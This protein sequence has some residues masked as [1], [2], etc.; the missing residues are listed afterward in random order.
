[1]EEIAALVSWQNG[2][3]IS[4]SLGS[5]GF[6]PVA[7]YRLHAAAAET[8]RFEQV[9]ESPGGRVLNVLDPVGVVAAIVPWNAPQALLAVK[10]APSLLAGCT[11][12]A[13][14]SPE[15]SLD[16]MLLAELLDEA[17]FPRGVVNIITG[18]RETGAAL[19][20]HSGVDMVSFTG[21]AVGGRD[22]ASACGQHL[23]EVTTEL[24]GKSAAVVLDDADLSQLAD[25]LIDTCLPNTGQ[26]C[27][28]STRI[29]APK[30]RL[31]EVLDAV[32]DTLRGARTGDPMDRDSQFGPLVTARQRERVEGYIAS[33]KADGARLA[34]GGG[35]PAG[36]AHGY[37][38][39]PTVFADVDPRMRIYQE[40]IFGP[41]LAITSYDD[42]ND[43]IRLA[44]DT[45]YGL[46][47][48]VFS[49]DFE[50]AVSVAREM[51]TG[52]VLIDGVTGVVPRG[53]TFQGRKSSGIGGGDVLRSFQM[54]KSI[55]LPRG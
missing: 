27:Y 35:R 32:L 48:S 24:G 41:V 13:K 6:A 11:V 21:S 30:S 46:C 40:E 22:V 2:A 1:M 42:D 5:N 50:R 38:V 33:G 23:K 36:L 45:T 7:S 47:G 8:E 37:Y 10:L 53:V 34:L 29:L 28:S 26:V 44:N 55:V 25:V 20:R 4:R 17:G 39:E 12:V 43:A 3:V 9:I 15:T 52:A 51:D 31:D 16:T 19:V 14:P 18:G 54:N 49:T